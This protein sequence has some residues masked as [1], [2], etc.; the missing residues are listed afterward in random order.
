MSVATSSPVRP[1]RHRPLTNLVPRQDTMTHRQFIASS[2]IITVALMFLQFAWAMSTPVFRGPDEPVH[3]NSVMR[4]ATT[5]TWPKAGEADIDPVI[6]DAAREAGLI[7]PNATSFASVNR[8]RL[9]YTDRNEGRPRVDLATITPPIERSSFGIVKGENP[10]STVVDQMTQHPPLYYAIAAGVVKIFHLWNTPWDTTIYTLRM[11]SIIILLPVTP[12]FIYTARRLGASRPWA[13]AAGLIPAMIPQFYHITTLVT[14]DVLT[15][16]LGALVMAALVTAGTEPISR[17]TIALVG[18]TLGLALWS[19]GQIL[20]FGLPLILVF[21]L[22][23]EPWRVRAKAIVA[24]GTVALIIGWWWL[25]N[26]LRYHT[27]QPGGYPQVYPDSWDPS[28]ADVGYFVSHALRAYNDSFWTAFGWLEVTFPILLGATLTIL[29]AITFVLGALKS[30][31]PATIFAMGSTAIGLMALL[32]GQAWYGSYLPGGYLSGLQ[33]RYAFPLIV[34]MAVCVLA[35]DQRS[36][37]ALNAFTM[38]VG[39]AASAGFIYLLKACYR[40]G[41]WYSNERMATQLGVEELTVRVILGLGALGLLVALATVIW[42]GRT[43][44][45]EADRA[46]R[47]AAC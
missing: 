19:K 26:I 9:H 18:A 5:G 28:Q 40:S 21:A 33:G 8:Y 2:A 23:P 4:V 11:L 47:H 16:S 37:Y 32:L 27:V 42:S 15:A 30:T 25:V 7:F 6:I 12:C 44:I 43:L 45:P 34:V 36:P 39:L 1:P 10:G 20:V 13:L 3:V 35:F 29:T 41:S 17:R 22:R 14:N 31:S 46:P 38:W 24:S